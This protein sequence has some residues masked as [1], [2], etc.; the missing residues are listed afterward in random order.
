ME[1]DVLFLCQE[2]SYITGIIIN[3]LVESLED[4]GY[5][6]LVIDDKLRKLGSEKWMSAHKR[7]YMLHAT[8]KYI[9]D[10][11]FPVIRET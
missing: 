8:T 9:V 7:C 6:S 1:K 2:E 4:L 5:S 10:E 11:A 3:S